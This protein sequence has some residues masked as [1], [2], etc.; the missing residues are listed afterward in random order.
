MAQ[1]SLQPRSAPQLRPLPRSART[2]LSPIRRTGA[3]SQTSGLIKIVNRPKR[4]IGATLQS[5]PEDKG[6]LGG[7]VEAAKDIGAFP[8]TVA[9]MAPTL[10]GKAAQSVYGAGETLFDIGADVVAPGAFT[11]RSEV[12]LAKGRA[13]GL[14]GPELLAYSMQ[15]TMP[16]FAP[17]VSSVPKTGARLAETATLGFLDTGAPGFDYYQALRQGELGNILLEDIGNVMLAGRTAGLGGV[18]QKAGRGLA[19]TRP[20]LATTL[21]RGGYFAE[22]PVAA[23]TRGVARLAGRGAERL[24]PRMTGRGAT[25]IRNIAAAGQRISGSETPLRATVQAGQYGF[26]KYAKTM[27]DEKLIVK[28]AVDEQVRAAQE[29]GV[30]VPQDLIDVQMK[31]SADYNKWNKLTNEQRALLRTVRPLRQKVENIGRALTQNFARYDEQGPIPDKVSTLRRTANNLRK[32]ADSNPERAD[33]LLAEA[34]YLELKADV[35][36]TDTTGRL[37]DREQINSSFAAAMLVGSKVVDAIDQM[38]ETGLTIDQAISIVLPKETTEFVRGQGYDITPNAVQK[39]LDYVRGQADDVDTISIK[40]ALG[41]AEIFSDFMQAQRQAGV[42]MVRGAA[43]PLEVGVMPMPE[44]VVKELSRYTTISKPVLDLLDQAVAYVIG[45]DI[46]ELATLLDIDLDNPTGL[47]EEFANSRPDSPQYAVAGRAI[48]EAL[49]I[50]RQD[51]QMTRI[52]DEPMI[53]PAPVRPFMVARRSAAEFAGGEDVIAYA[54][55]LRD[56]NDQNPG[57][58]PDG[59][60]NRIE[61]AVNI[62]NDPQKRYD[63]KTMPKVLTLINAVIKAV[64][65]ERGKI[66]KAKGRLA[67]RTDAR[68]ARLDEIASASRAAYGMVQTIIDNPELFAN[69]ETIQE[70]AALREEAGAATAQLEAMGPVPEGPT[71]DTYD[72]R[73]ALGSENRE[74]STERQDISVKLGEVETELN[75]LRRRKQQADKVTWEDEA[76]LQA[77]LD[78]AREIRDELSGT[79]ELSDADAARLKKEEILNL[80]RLNEAY[81]NFIGE[82]TFAKD[83]LKIEDNEAAVYFAIGPDRS[84]EVF[85]AFVRRFGR[86]R[87]PKN[88]NPQV[89]ISR[90]PDGEVIDV[91]KN[92]YS[93]NDLFSMATSYV[94]MAYPGYLDGFGVRPD[95]AIDRFVR[96]FVDYYERSRRIAEIRKSNLETYKKQKADEFESQLFE[97]L[98]RAYQAEGVRSP[99]ELNRIIGDYEDPSL[100]N[101]LIADAEGRARELR[102]RDAE[103]LDKYN[104]NKSKSDQLWER[105]QASIP[106]ERIAEAQRLRGIERGATQRASEL[107]STVLPQQAA[108]VRARLRGVGVGREF[109]WGF[110]VRMG[111]GFL[112]NIDAEQE[113]ILKKQQADWAKMQELRARLDEQDR[114]LASAQEIGAAGGRREAMLGQ[115]ILAEMG[116]EAPLY[117]PT[118]ASRVV[119][120]KSVVETTIRSQA[121]APEAVGSFEQTRTGTIMPMTAGQMAAR[122]REILQVWGRN[123]IIQSIINN[124]DYVSNVAESIPEATREAFRTQAEQIVDGSGIPRNTEQYKKSVDAEYGKLLFDELK[125]RGLDPISP[126]QMPDPTDP[127][128]ERSALGALQE[129]VLSSDV[130]DSTLVMTTNMRNGLATQFEPKDI[131]RGY[132]RLNDMFIQLREKTAAWKSVILPFSV[133]WQVGDAV[134]NVLNAWVRGEVPPNELVGYIRMANRMFRDQ[135]GGTRRSLMFGEGLEGFMAN[136]VAQAM[137][138]MGLQQSGLKT[139]ELRSTRRGTLVSPPGTFGG[140]RMFPRVR[141]ASFAFNE[142]QNRLVRHAVALKKLTDILDEQGRTIDEVSPVSIMQ[143]DA[144]RAAVEEAVNTTNEALGNFS[145]LDPYERQVVRSV[146]PFWSWIKFINKAAAELILDQPDRVLFMAHLGGLMMEPEAEGLWDFLK[147]DTNIPGLGITDLSFINPYSDAFLFSGNPLASALETGTSVSPILSFGATIPGELYYGATGRRLPFAKTLSRPGYLEGRPGETARTWGDVFGGLGYRALRDFGGPFRNVIDI[148]PE[149]RIPGTDIATGPVE[150]FGQGSRRTEGQFGVRRLSPTK[151]RLSAV[152]RTFGLPAPKIEADV[153]ARIAA[154]NAINSRRVRLQ[155]SQQKRLAQR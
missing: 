76:A 118:G 8:V 51:P 139:A 152:A 126:V 77:E 124:K 32:Q 45:R 19:A 67:A 38:L 57:I 104:R 83:Q 154:E 54:G 37:A 60:V 110:G 109:A 59:I 49:P 39:A 153:A 115:P 120:P 15:R 40:E 3:A 127:Y 114:A 41:Y 65:K 117:I 58:L 33:V 80:K 16:F 79:T 101:G 113:S 133:R 100:I 84:P 7:L 30:E 138:S 103:L 129:T 42:G 55:A 95:Q 46:P 147:G 64:N 52:L 11:S 70:A 151:G 150:R 10:V 132:A 136:P 75:A 53:Y 34:D 91:R 85:K 96:D 81:D 128:A 93:D 17:I 6:I 125:R 145:Q 122:V 89:L 68:W 130:T 111:R 149:G 141:R 26:G 9:R 69:Q 28:N 97:E 20:R 50:I 56:F 137:E 66:I 78:R 31:A 121:V 29:A 142:F 22:Q 27:A 13:M 4:T 107:E 116:G 24:I 14:K 44:Y 43:S 108:N 106:R 74:I 73:M 94:E 135:P 2:P 140:D 72:E 131:A 18:A 119:E 123:A 1:S 47:F 134:G 143:D 35:K 144:L 23:T 86:P 112:K 146:F 87:T 155:R 25:T 36:E 12:D 5:K 82:P 98:D 148:L 71:V 62:A 48:E 90:G 99:E 61:D 21:R 63:P 105:Q 102:S 88:F 92:P